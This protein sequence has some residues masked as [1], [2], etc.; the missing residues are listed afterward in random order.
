MN[1][2]FDQLISYNLTNNKYII[3]YLFLLFYS[4]QSVLEYTYT[5][6]DKIFILSIRETFQK[7][8]ILVEL[9]DDENW[10]TIIDMKNKYIE[11]NHLLTS[12]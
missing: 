12:R 10:E 4:L 8:K 5:S 11:L 6:I 7:T 3:F 1:F 2:L 9:Y